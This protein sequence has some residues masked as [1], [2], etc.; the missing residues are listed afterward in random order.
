MTS[1]IPTHTHCPQLEQ[2]GYCRRDTSQDLLPLSTHWPYKTSISKASSVGRGCDKRVYHPLHTAVT[3]YCR[4]QT[5]KESNIFMVIY[6]S[7]PSLF[8]DIFGSEIFYLFLLGHI[9]VTVT[10]T[11]LLCKPVLSILAEVVL[12]NIKNII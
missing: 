2:R 10:V 1:L 11:H 8:P 9:K 6:G 3:L 7:L 4:L 12:N 5:T